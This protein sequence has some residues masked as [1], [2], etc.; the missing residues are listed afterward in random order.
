M[1]KENFSEALKLLLLLLS[2]GDGTEGQRGRKRENLKQTPGQGEPD[3]GLNLTTLRSRL[4]LRS[5]QVL[6]TLNHPGAPS[7]R[8]LKVRML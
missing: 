4:E 7:L 5:S 2:K 8:I 6:N 3:V 1:E